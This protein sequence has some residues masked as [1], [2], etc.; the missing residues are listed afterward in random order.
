MKSKV[1]LVFLLLTSIAQ[2]QIKP[3]GFWRSFLPYNNAISAATNGTSL[4]AISD[5]SFYAY[6]LATNETAAYSK[7]EG[8]SDVGMNIVDYDPVS[9]YTILVYNNCNI[10]FFK[11]ETFFNLPDIKLKSITGL[12]RVNNLF[13][14]DGMAYLSTSFGI[15]VIN[16]IKK[17]V[18]ETY[19]F[20]SNNQNI[21]IFSMTEALGYLFAITDKGVFKANKNNPNLQA[22]SSWQKLT[23]K[24]N[25]T[26]ITTANNK[27]LINTKDSLFTLLNDTLALVY[28]SPWTI[29]RIDSIDSKIFINEYR[30]AQFNGVVHVLNSDYQMVDSFSTKGKP[31]RTMKT[32]DDN[33]WISDAFSGLGKRNGNSTNDGIHPEGPATYS[34]FDILPFNGDVWVAHGG[35]NDNWTYLFNLKGFSHYQNDKWKIY[36]EST[37]WGL[38][39]LTDFSSLAK[40]PYDGSLYVGSFRNGILKLHADGVGYDLIKYNGV[41]EPTNGD[42]T[43]YR[44]SGLTFDYNGNLWFTISGAPHE[45]YVKTQTG[46]FMKFAGPA[47]GQYAGFPIVDDYNQKWYIIPGTGLA[48]YNDNYTTENTNDDAYLRVTT[49]SISSSVNC[50]VKDKDGAIWFGTS[51]GIGVINCPGQMIEGSCQIDRPIVQYDQFAGYLF[52]NENV[53]ALAVDGANRKWVGTA[54]GVWLI[55][56]TG[57]KI[58]YRFTVDNSPLPTNLIQKIAIDP[59]TGEVFIGTSQGLVS[60]RSTATEGGETNSNVTTYPSPI[61]SGYGGT[62]AIKGLVSNGDVKITDV[63]GQ[64]I[65]RTQALGGQAVWNGKDYTGHRPQSGVYL[66]FVTN[67]DGSETFAGKLVFME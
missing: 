53:K 15:V 2:A 13:V 8:M 28:S 46:N 6:N 22:F 26:Y 65:Y 51:D 33:I 38:H 25:F 67:K 49:S 61:P 30:D 14:K 20:I 18:K 58:I 17:E 19:S 64:L 35:F 29:T 7:V 32:A 16:L 42:T 1:V 45:L 24:N 21:E 3:I 62:I 27:T 9:G 37:D 55:S 36:N 50:L 10:D 63:T 23:S 43:S 60:F 48:V 59:V 52:Q 56:A 12:K 41:M 47:N 4:F 31:V 11:N 66:I 34:S 57:D 40:D 44:V 39:D 5:Q 54:N